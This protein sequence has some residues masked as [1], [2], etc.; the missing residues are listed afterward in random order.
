MKRAWADNGLTAAMATVCVLILAAFGLTHRF[1]HWAYDLYMRLDPAE[2]HP[3]VLVVAIDSPSLQQLGPWPWPRSLHAR[4]IERLSDGDARLIVTALPYTLPENRSALEI[5]RGIRAF[6]EESALAG[7]SA[8]TAR[9]SARAAPSPRRRRTA[10]RLLQA[11]TAD[12]ERLHQRLQQAEERL[13]GDQALAAAM[14]RAGNVILPVAMQP[15]PPGASPAPALPEVATHHALTPT[16]PA[17]GAARHGRAVI[18]LTALTAAAAAL[19]HGELPPDRD[20]LLRGLPAILGYAGGGLYPALG[21]AAAARA[22]DPQL[23]RLALEPAGVVLNGG[24]LHTG[25]GLRIHPRWTGAEGIEVI[26][27]KDLLEGR[28][29]PGHLRDRIVLFGPTAHAAAERIATPVDPDA[30]EVLVHA[31]V[32]SAL[33]SGQMIRLPAQASWVRIGAA[34][35]AALCLVF[36]LHRLGRGWGIGLSLGLTA[37]LACAEF[38]LLDRMSIWL[39]LALGEGILLAAAA[40]LILKALAEKVR[41]RP[42]PGD[43]AAQVERTRGLALLGQGDLDRAFERFRR[44]PLNRAMMELL[45]KLGEDYEQRRRFDRAREV[46]EY[47]SGYNPGFRDL[48]RRLQR[49]RR[50]EQSINAAPSA[51]PAPKPVLGRYRIERELG[52]GAMGTVY[53]GVDPKIGRTVAIKTMPLSAEFEEGEL[54]AVKARFFREAETAGRLSHPNIVT[55]YDAGEVQD[56]AY[57]AMEY[58]PGQN[59][60]PYTRLNNLLP[61][62]EAM[63]VIARCAEALAYAHRRHVVHR[64][65]K[66][67][68]IM[69]EARSGTLKITDFGIAR[70]TDYS[71]TKTGMVLG[72]P[73]YMSPEQLAGKKVDG[74]SDLFS[75]GVML[76]QLTTG[77]LPFKAESMA[78][79]MHKIANDE[80]PPLRGLRPEAPPCLQAIVERALAKHPQRRYQDGEALARDLHECVKITRGGTES[81]R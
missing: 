77:E 19:G 5:L 67:A 80:P 72:T 13:A 40:A 37:A 34:A 28:L 64:D 55:I 60:T 79:L 14:E 31:Q 27:A 18:P 36:V 58:L 73:S 65:I 49:A 29:P 20:G 32:V 22:D 59:L 68:N 21:L 42:Q 62:D 8:E 47:M 69:Y 23:P 2:A 63:E 4:I 52:K 17:A 43:E 33:L 15:G 50:L 61:L 25:P 7:L 24:R 39:P 56:L 75:L 53:L 6:L 51:P 38:I 46:Y 66:P 74:R 81:R 57:I 41:R 26:S 16:Q 3:Q 35:G 54:D 45:Y 30:P 70:I 9:L 78:A 1:E 44:V 48:P 76:F 11:A 10:L 12:L 71:R